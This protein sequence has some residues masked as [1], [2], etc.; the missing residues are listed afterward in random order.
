MTLDRG[1]PDRAVTLIGSEQQPVAALVHDASLVGQRP[2]LEAAGSAARLALETV[3]LNAELR[4]QLSELRESRTRIVSA[5]DAE[6]RRLERDLHDGAQQRLLAIGLV[7]QLL[8]D[9]DADPQLLGEAET[10]LQAA[11][12][13]LRELA[14]GIH[15]AIPTDQ[16]LSAAIDSLVDRAPLRVNVEVTGEA[17]PT[18]DRERRLLHRLRS[19]RQHHQ[20]RTR[21]IRDRDDRAPGQPSRDPNS[22]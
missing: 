5:G 8:R 11:L 1:S 22:R 19:A 12:H 15:P 10:E 6:R 16:G 18:R 14:R 2:L 3:R 17:L 4:A 7:L 13:E 9:A 21:T 20:A